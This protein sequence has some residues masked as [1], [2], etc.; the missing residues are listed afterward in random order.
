M[1]SGTMI[2]T[3][4]TEVMRSSSSRW[5]VHFLFGQAGSWREPKS[6]WKCIGKCE[7]LADGESINLVGHRHRYF[8]F[9]AKQSVQAAVQQVR[10]VVVAGRLVKFEVKLESLEG[11]RIEV[12][13]LR[14][15]DA[16]A[17]QEISSILPK[18]QSP[19]FE[20]AHH[21][22]LSFDRSMEQLG[23]RSIF[24]T[25]LVAANIAWF[26]VVASQGGGWLL[27]KPGVIIQFGSN[28]PFRS[29]NFR[30]FASIKFAATTTRP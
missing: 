10:N 30:P 26:A 22:K 11:E 12:V 15:S 17:A 5:A 21:E 20:R 27:P 2:P 7:L 19:E 23:T 24:T 9:P 6:Q 13:R 8:R 28:V 14:T 3:A 4:D 25:T 16:Q 18:T 29:S 1:E